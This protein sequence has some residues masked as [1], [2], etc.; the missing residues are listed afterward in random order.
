MRV[1]PHGTLGEDGDNGRCGFT[2]FVSPD[3]ETEG[4][5]TGTATASETSNGERDA[6]AIAITLGDDSLGARIDRVTADYPNL[7][8]L[9]VANSRERTSTA[10]PTF[11]LRLAHLATATNSMLCHGNDAFSATLIITEHPKKENRKGREKRR[12]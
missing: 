9:F 5:R 10:V 3:L 8:R 11:R 6:D 4:R 12:P 7:M 2:L 1:G